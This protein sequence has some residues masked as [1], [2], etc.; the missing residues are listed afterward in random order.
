MPSTP[1]PSKGYIDISLSISPQLPVWPGSP[2][3]LFQRSHDL[4]SGD[5]VNDTTIKFSVHTGTHVDAPCHFLPEGLSVDRLD[6]DVM[7]GPAFV[8]SLPDS[9]SVITS[10]TLAALEIPEKTERLLIRTRNSQLWENKVASFQD[11]YVALTADAARWIVDNKIKLV[12]VDYLS[13]QRFLD[14]PEAHLVL[15]SDEIIIIEA[16]NLSSIKEGKYEL[17]CLPIKLEGIE[18]APARV[19]LRPITS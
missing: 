2:Q 4:A 10:E 3:V 8:A 11:D 16:L 9:A 15:L 18:G 19:L 13:V 14:G 12:G 7:I 17:I 1:N 5:G 6:L